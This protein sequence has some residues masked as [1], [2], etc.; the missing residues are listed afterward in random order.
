MNILHISPNF[1]WC[2]IFILPIAKKQYEVGNCVW[3]STPENHLEI[4]CN[5]S[6]VKFVSWHNKYNKFLSHIFHSFFLI[7]Q[8]RKN[9]IHKVYLHTTLDSFFY[10]L[11]LRFFTSAEVVY[12]NHGV[13]Y[14]G[15][16]GI[17]RNLF[18]FVEFSNL[19]FSHKTIVITQSMSKLLSSFLFYKEKLFFLNPG[20][21]VGV[22]IKYKDYQQLLDE[23]NKH[24]NKNKIRII[25]IGRPEFR[26]GIYDLLKGLSGTRLNYELI[27]LG[28]EK[29]DINI[30]LDC[31]KVKVLGYKKD[32][33][34]FY[35]SSDILCVPSHHEGFGQIYL[36]AASFGVIPICCDIPGPTDFIK[37]DFNGLVVK[38]KSAE[39]IKELF[40]NISDGLFDLEKLKYNAYISSFTYSSE[41]VVE[42]N[43]EFFI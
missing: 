34:L 31:N 39:E 16:K 29:N 1:N 12:V 13:P 4:N 37:H 30:D 22:N 35:L 36:E 11:M 42:K 18:K 26:K 8:I 33:E 21:M 6:G 3:I 14:V 15:Y 25:F 41:T 28:C 32:L 9:R 40:D 38:P 10:V 2:T 20:T 27:I 5:E 24:E 7:N 43:M 19:N 17:I 23:R